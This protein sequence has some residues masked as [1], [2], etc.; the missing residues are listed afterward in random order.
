MQCCGAGDWA[1][2]IFCCAAG[3]GLLSLLTRCSIDMLL[4]V[5]IWADWHFC[6]LLI[7]TWWQSLMTSWSADQAGDLKSRGGRGGGMSPALLT[8]L[9]SWAGSSRV[10][11]WSAD[12]ANNLKWGGGCAW[13]IIMIDQL[14]KIQ[15]VDVM[16]SWSDGM[17]WRHD[18]HGMLCR[19]DQL[20]RWNAVAAW[21]VW[22]V[23]S[24]W[25]TE[26]REYCD[27]MISWSGKC[28]MGS[29]F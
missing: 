19:H 3:F 23:V 12:H 11:S 6:S 5:K 8:W 7:F 16:I 17:L 29:N 28:G 24:S 13:T 20:I 9:I 10:T 21:S 22:N 25:S 26:K 1:G 27:D 14:M 2:R 18:Q 4:G 15:C